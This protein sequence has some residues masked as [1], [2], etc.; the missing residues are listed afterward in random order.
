MAG[1]RTD[2]NHHRRRAWPHVPQRQ[3]GA[4]NNNDQRVHDP[5]QP[6]QH[7]SLTPVGVGRNGHRRRRR[8]R[9]PDPALQNQERRRGV[10]LCGPMAEEQLTR[11]VRF[12]A[13]MI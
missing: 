2:D 4:H 10:H 5:V 6:Q 1:H 3:H 9:P 7:A 11:R 12:R 8:H 13:L